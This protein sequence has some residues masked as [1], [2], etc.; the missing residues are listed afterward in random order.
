MSSRAV[1]AIA[2]WTATAMGAVGAGLFALSAIGAGIIDRTVE[3]MTSAQVQAALADAVTDT[4]RASSTPRPSPTATPST[5]PRAS[6]SPRT[7]KAPH[8]WVGP[9]PTQ[10]TRSAVGAPRSLNSE[11]GNVLARCEQNLAY[12]VSWTPMQGY[13]ADD[14]R[15]GP[16]TDVSVQF[17]AGD[18]K[19][20]M[21]VTCRDGRPAA[22]VRA[23]G[24][25]RHHDDDGGEGWEGWDR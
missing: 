7:S 5:T 8:A 19:V 12:L 11:G 1:L 6:R 14:A 20:T 18:R 9:S 15:R 24:H 21:T 13:R 22:T 10:V 16:A 3:P 17:E 23:D 4:P 25:T 2:A